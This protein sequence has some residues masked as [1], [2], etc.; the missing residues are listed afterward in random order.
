MSKNGFF[1]L[2]SRMRHIT[3]WGLMR[4]SSREN[5]QEHSHMV[6][7]LAHALALIGNRVFSRSYNADRAAVIAL[8]HDATEIITG[9]MPTPIKYH[10]ERIRDAY[11]AVEALSTKRLLE[12]APPPLQYDLAQAL[13]PEDGELEKL[14]KA[15]DSLSAY[16][17]CVEELKAGNDEFRLAG[18]Q[19]YRKL[20]NMELPECD[21]FMEHCLPS[22]S[23]TLDELQND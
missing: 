1:A 13:D 6:A 7:V 20:K 3:R 17:K 22:F 15:A 23:L 19:I 8:Y 10:D 9:D 21:W 16:I 11:K 18:E 5:V 12:M 14:V 4:N 2:I